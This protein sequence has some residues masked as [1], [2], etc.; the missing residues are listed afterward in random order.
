MVQGNTQ[1]RNPNTGTATGPVKTA[2]HWYTKLFAVWIVLFA[3]IGYFFPQPFVFLAKAKMFGPAAERWPAVFQSL[4]SPNLWFFSL[5]MF[6]I[7]AVLTVADFKNITKRPVIVL[8]GCI[9]QFTI[10]PAG[11]FVLSKLFGL[12]PMLAAGLIIAGCA[13]GAAI[14]TG[15]VTS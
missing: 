8:I 14:A 3:V 12:D 5:T 9:A 7:G 10:M 1:N 2:L 6:G 15:V 4:R 13:P 11:A